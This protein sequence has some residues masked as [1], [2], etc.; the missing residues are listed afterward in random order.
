MMLRFDEPLFLKNKIR[1]FLELQNPTTTLDRNLLYS[2]STKIATPA[3][4]AAM[5]R[6][7][8]TGIMY[9]P[10]KHQRETQADREL[11]RHL[12]QLFNQIMPGR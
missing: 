6:G 3:R 10:N 11:L 2:L 5:I 8:T 9:I 4:L 7:L 12:P 1:S